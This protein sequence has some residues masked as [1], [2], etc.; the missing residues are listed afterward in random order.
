MHAVIVFYSLSGTTRRLAGILAERIGPDAVLAEIGCA[1]YRAGSGLSF[2]R[3][4]VDSLLGLRPPVR[5]PAADPA[6]FDV[7]LI[8]GPVWAARPATP[9]VA[10]LAA[11]PRLPARVGLF[12]VAGGPGQEAALA[13]LR[14]LLP[15]PP[16]AELAVTEGEVRAGAPAAV[17]P[18]LAALGIDRAG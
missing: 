1:R 12:L 8:G 17:G 7:A 15:G 16:A 4:A 6:R 5:P 2:A 18:F 3:A 13:R 9:L 10:W 11:R 14:R